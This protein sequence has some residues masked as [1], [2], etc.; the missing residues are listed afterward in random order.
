MDYE[1]IGVGRYER[2]SDPRSERRGGRGT[3]TLKY[4]IKKWVSEE[5][6]GRADLPELYRNRRVCVS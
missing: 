3:S 4:P 1:S 2:L 5:N 6:I